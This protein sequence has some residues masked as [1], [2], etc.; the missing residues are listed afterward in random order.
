MAVYDSDDVFAD[1]TDADWRQV[2]QYADAVRYLQSADRPDPTVA[3]ARADGVYDL[4]PVDAVWDVFSGNCEDCIDRFVNA[5][6]GVWSGAYRQIR[7]KQAYLDEIRTYLDGAAPDTTAYDEL[8]HW[9]DRL[10]V[11]EAMLDEMLTMPDELLEMAGGAPDD[12]TP[13]AVL[14]GMNLRERYTFQRQV[15]ADLRSVMYDW[16][17]WNQPPPQEPTVLN[18]A[19]CNRFQD[20]IQDLTGIDPKPTDSGTTA[21][22]QTDE[23]P[24]DW[25]RYGVES[26]EEQ[27]YMEALARFQADPKTTDVDA[28]L[29]RSVI[30]WSR[31][32]D[33][34]ALPYDLRRD[35]RLQTAAAAVKRHPELYNGNG[36]GTRRG[37]QTTATTA[38]HIAERLRSDE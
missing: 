11:G 27:E 32:G 15:A 23:S 7:E 36:S 16:E 30:S 37:L 10:A 18:T 4:D 25:G 24:I 31:F 14:Q 1:M 28:D 17:P 8:A 34:D 35:D 38:A 2:E 33:T 6:D 12:N 20:A 9:T 21:A 26:A 22:E 19:L 5:E 29:L 3:A 13:D